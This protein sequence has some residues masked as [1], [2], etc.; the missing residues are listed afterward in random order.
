MEKENKKIL[1]VINF[2]EKYLDLSTEAD[3]NIKI[4]FDM[5]EFKRLNICNDELRQILLSLQ[6][7]RIIKIDRDLVLNFNELFNSVYKSTAKKLFGRNTNNLSDY[8]RALLNIK[9]DK[10]FKKLKQEGEIIITIKDLTAF[11]KYKFILEQEDD[12]IIHQI[13]YRKNREIVLDRKRTI[14]QPDFNSE[15]DN[16]FEY[17]YNNPNKKIDLQELFEKIGTKKKVSNIL[18]DLKFTGDLKRIFFPASSKTAI[19][20]INPVRKKYL[21]E[22]GL[23]PIK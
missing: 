2:I 18:S 17:V 9:S 1:K 4:G 22:N 21:K 8:D 6:Q 19:M 11:K 15:N 16:F 13:E 3:K 20:F 14:A 7:K 12:V 5:K 10:E 23:K